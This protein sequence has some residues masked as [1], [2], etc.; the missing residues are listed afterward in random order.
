[1]SLWETFG[2]KKN[3]FDAKW[4]EVSEE[5]YNLFVGR[6]A[7][8]K[9]FQTTISSTQGGLI[10]VEGGVG[11]GKTSFVNVQQY[12]SFKEKIKKTP[13]LLP[14]FEPISIQPP[15]N[16]FDVLLS[17]LS[18]CVYSFIYLYGE[19]KIKR[20]KQLNRIYSVV[21][22][23]LHKTSSVQLGAVIPPGIGAS[24]GLG[25]SA[26]QTT[27]VGV[28][29]HIL[30]QALDKLVEVMR[31]KYQFDGISVTINNLDIVNE[32]DVITFFDRFRDI[33]TNR[34]YFWWI[35]IGPE[36]LF[37]LLETK[38][39]R[40]SE[41]FIGQPTLLPPLS[42][43]NIKEAIER[44]I[45]HFRLKTG[46]KSPVPEEVVKILYETSKGEI[47]FIFKR[48]TDFIIEFKT[49]YPSAKFLNYSESIYTLKNLIGR[50]L[51]E[52]NLTDA[53]Q[54]M[55]QK[56]SR[57]DNFRPKD[58]KLFGLISAQSLS[59]YIKKFIQLR[60]LYRSQTGKAAI[61]RCSGDV[62]L[63]FSEL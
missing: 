11:V 26:F 47:R 12:I 39:S 59:K 20:D 15:I 27:P 52:V 43:G 54:N 25:K 29:L 42:Y 55:L 5:G 14:C 7:Q 30:I 56:F 58:F 51:N 2:F 38:R 31:K 57:V 1:M 18:S 24:F 10:I 16:Q 4:L 21:N 44:R 35:F 34:K 19:E 60:L 28:S 61:Y 53:E 62:K 45:K 33:L 41:I 23:T 8:T 6:E 37:S 17:I 50:R 46:I 63:F 36:G 22:Q 32:E 40:V 13:K 48:L 9:Q 3:P 49:K